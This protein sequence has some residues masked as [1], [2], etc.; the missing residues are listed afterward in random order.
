VV[1]ALAVVVAWLGLFVRKLHE[2]N[3]LVH[4]NLH[5]YYYYY[6]YLPLHHH[7]HHHHHHHLTSSSSI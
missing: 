7:H 6:Y 5:Y 1:V 3:W 4:I 2:E